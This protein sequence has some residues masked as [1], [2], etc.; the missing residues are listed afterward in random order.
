MSPLSKVHEDATKHSLAASH[1]NGAVSYHQRCSS[2]AVNRFLC[3]PCESLKELL[4]NVFAGRQAVTEPH[5]ADKCR[6]FDGRGELVSWED[7]GI[8]CVG[9]RL[10][11]EQIIAP[12]STVVSSQTWTPGHLPHIYASKK[13]LIGDLARKTLV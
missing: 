5:G 10:C 13:T 2:V 6:C 1:L 11:I 12:R 9:C 3:H 7:N 4:H 8:C